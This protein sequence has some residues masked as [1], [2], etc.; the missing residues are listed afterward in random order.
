MKQIIVKNYGEVG[1]DQAIKAVKQGRADAV[2]F[3]VHSKR[4]LCICR[5]QKV[6]GQVSWSEGD[7]WWSQTM[8]VF[9]K[10]RKERII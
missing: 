7:F 4:P 9:Q 3:W 8:S 6:S 2:A 10:M 5:A 1:R